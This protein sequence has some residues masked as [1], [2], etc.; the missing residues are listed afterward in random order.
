[1]RFHVDQTAGARNRRVIRRVLIQ[2]N[3]HKAP[4]PQRIRQLPGNPPFTADALEVAQ[5]QRPK[6]DPRA[7][8]RPAILRRIELR[9]PSLHKLIELL[10]LQ[11]FIEPLLERMSWRRGQLR[12]SDPNVFLLFPLLARSHCHT[13]ILRI[14]PVDTS[15]FFAH[16][17]GL[18]PRAA[19][20][21]SE[22]STVNR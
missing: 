22:Y 16:A 12:M 20:S 4:Q 9:T 19:R 1:M 3:P 14:L 15:H 7:Q 11:Q 2:P 18:T 13:R 5:Q 17:S 21:V 10:S 6:V 8:R